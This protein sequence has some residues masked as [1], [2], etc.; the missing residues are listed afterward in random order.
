MLIPWRVCVLH[1]KI[2]EGNVAPTSGLAEKADPSAS[3]TGRGTSLEAAKGQRLSDLF[4]VEFPYGFLCYVVVSNMFFIF[5]SIWGND[6][7]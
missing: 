1:P 2:N 7:I 5:T 6:P 4:F 3:S